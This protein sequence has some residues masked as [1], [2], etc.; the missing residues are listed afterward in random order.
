[1]TKLQSDLEN[2]FLSNNSCHFYLG[3][4]FKKHLHLQYLKIG[5]AASELLQREEISLGMG[6]NFYKGRHHHHHHHYQIFD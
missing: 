5:N 6:S 2:I 3:K 1:M 4:S